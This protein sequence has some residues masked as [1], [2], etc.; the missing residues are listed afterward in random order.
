VKIY[1]RSPRS[2]AGRAIG[3][4]RGAAAVGGWR[5][6]TRGAS[7]L[8]YHDVTDNPAYASEQ[9]SPAVLR[10]QLAGAV[11]WGMQFVPLPEL[12]ERLLRGA[13]VDGLAAI[14]FDDALVG[15]HRNAIGVLA[16]LGLPATVFVVSDRLGVASPDWYESSDRVMTVDEL[17]EVADAGLDIQS[18]T[19]T[20]ADLPTL[21]DPALDGELGGSRAAL[22]DLVGRDVQYLAY[23]FGHFDAHVCAAARQAGY[24]AAFTFRNGR[25]TR[26]L[27]PYRLPRLPMWTGAGRLRLAY[28]LARP[29]WSFPVH[30]R[31]A[32]T[33]TS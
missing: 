5:L 10:A 30:Q 11:R 29:P 33:D 21:D 13:P 3:L 22:S 25:V 14:T 1:G 24:R 15:V 20:H 6:R 23:P 18:H 4:A 31:R 16:E 19:R 27:D 12:G 32:V 17:R 7:V 28:N 8:T 2:L 9:V 26:G